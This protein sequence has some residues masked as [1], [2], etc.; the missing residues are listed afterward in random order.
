MQHI[1]AMSA[2]Q[3][4]EPLDRNADAAECVKLMVSS[5]PW[6]TL[7]LSPETALAV[8]TDPVKE[9]HAIRDADRI[10][11]FVVIDMRGLLRGYVQILC[12]REDSRRGSRSR[13]SRGRA[14]GVSDW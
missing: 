5:E 2:D 6:L 4:I 7:R 8:L 1:I 3:R 13:P 12:V 14:L 9:V 11:G 10:A